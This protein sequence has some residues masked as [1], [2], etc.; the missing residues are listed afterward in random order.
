MLFGKNP[1]VS[2]IVPV[3][4]GERYLA[5]ALRSVFA[6]SY[7]KYEVIV[8]DDGSTDQSVAVAKTFRKARFFRQEHQGAAKARNLAIAKSKGQILAFLD[9]D[10]LWLPEK[11][12]IQVNYLMD[13]PEIGYV[14]ARQKIFFEKNAKLPQKVKKLVALEKMYQ[15]AH[16]AYLPG[17]LVLWRAVMDKVGYFDETLTNTSDTDWLFRAKDMG[18]KS[19]VVP[20]VLLRKRFHSDNSCYNVHIT[21]NEIL[22]VIRQ[23]I[24]RQKL[25]DPGESES[26]NT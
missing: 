24:H 23:S 15:S 11:L 21:R 5:D 6:Q 14:F 13:H 22:R 3:F 2:V 12:K 19:G 20:R 7:K 25:H 9:Q 10:D 16:A 4:N 26:R 1:L 8:V 18:I 17:T